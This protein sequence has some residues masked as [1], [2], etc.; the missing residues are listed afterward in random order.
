MKLCM[1]L[2]RH[3]FSKTLHDKH[4]SELEWILILFN[5]VFTYVANYRIYLYILPTAFVEKLSLK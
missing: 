4:I 1:C 2:A 3:R 5:D